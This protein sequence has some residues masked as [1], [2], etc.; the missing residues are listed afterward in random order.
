[1]GLHWANGVFLALLALCSFEAHAA[2]KYKFDFGWK[3]SPGDRHRAPC[4]PGTFPV[5]M[6]DIQCMG[7]SQVPATGT[8]DCAAACCEDASC[9]TWQ[10]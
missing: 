4:K 6:T 8:E 9:E 5:D 3:F 7:L 10:W 1:M 2:Q